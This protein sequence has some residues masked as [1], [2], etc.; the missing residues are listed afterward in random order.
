MPIGGY[1]NDTFP[2]GDSAPFGYVPSAFPLYSGSASGSAPAVSLSVVTSTM[3]KATPPSL[4]AVFGTGNKG[5]QNNQELFTLTGWFAGHPAFGGP[6][7]SLNH[8]A[9]SMTKLDP[10]GG[11][12]LSPLNHGVVDQ[13]FETPFAA[14]EL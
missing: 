2:N 12:H 6:R 8:D 9:Q 5:H 11:L 14:Q 13:L 4:T 3:Q 1:V 7:L 10:V